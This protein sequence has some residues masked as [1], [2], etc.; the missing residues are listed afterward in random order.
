M[1]SVK[2]AVDARGLTGEAS[3]SG[4][5]TYIRNLLGGLATVPDLDVE[6]LATRDADVPDGVRRISIQRFTDARRRS[7][8]E[9]AMRVPVDLALRSRADV[10]HNP[11]FYAPPAI[12]RPWVQTLFDVIPLVD[13]DPALEGLRHMW[14]RFGPRYRRAD[15]LIAISRHAADEGTRFLDLRPERVHVIYLGVSPNY[16]PDGPAVA[17]DPPYLLV[18]SQFSR[19]KGFGEAF[20][21]IARLAEAGYPHHLKVAGWVPDNV[22]PELDDL[23]AHAER[24]DRIEVLGFVPDLPALIRG[25]SVMLV[26]SRYE[27]FGLP[28]V[29]GMA[30]GVPLVAFHNSSLVEIVEGG[31]VLVAD[32]D[33]VAMT[34]AARSLLDSAEHRADVIGRGLARAEAFSWTACAAATADVY[35]AVAAK[36]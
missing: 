4:I 16:R 12:R 25:A 21:V 9:H 34:A 10:F 28:A 26:P 6:A 20:S 13:D 2:V 30:S 8:L 19:R 23:L 1:P 27:G 5:G 33:V 17:S 15:A 7:V 35:R 11:L 22:R 29:E 3:R 18:V 24:P 31:G 14:R 36:A 32:G